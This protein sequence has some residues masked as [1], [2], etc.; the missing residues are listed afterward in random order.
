MRP[1]HHLESPQ[2]QAALK[3]IA[4]FERSPML[5]VVDLTTVDL[6]LPQVLQVSTAQGASITFGVENLE[7]QLRRWHLVHDYAL[8][9]A[10]TVASLD[11]SVSNN[12]P[13]R[14]FEAGAAPPTRPKPL[15]PSPYKKK[16]V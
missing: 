15:K 1:G 7:Q 12:V 3:L 11:L 13:A 16:H 5:G 10:K 4:E 2:I 14:W 9:S 6:S 8:R